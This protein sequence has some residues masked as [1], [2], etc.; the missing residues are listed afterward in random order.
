MM[1]GTEP[2]AAI[3][4]RLK[5]KAKRR[6]SETLTMTEAANEI[7]DALNI[8]YEAAMMTLYGLCATGEVRWLDDQGELVDEDECT[9]G[10]FNKKPKY[11]VA[12][13]VRSTLTDWRGGPVFRDRIAA[14]LTWFLGLL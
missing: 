13:D 14:C 11:V 12:S 1:G 6:S 4:E 8:K 3:V 5:A 2:V 9:I 10:D 7:A